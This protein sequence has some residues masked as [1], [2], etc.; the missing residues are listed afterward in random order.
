M[1]HGQVANAYRKSDTFVHITVVVV[2]YQPIQIQ[3]CITLAQYL[4]VSK[5]SAADV[6]SMILG[7]QLQNAVCLEYN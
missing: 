7:E 2:F 6:P 4:Y 5:R 1:Y 3:C